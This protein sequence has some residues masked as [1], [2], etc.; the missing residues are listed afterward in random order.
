MEAFGQ[1]AAD[2][3]IGCLQA[4]HRFQGLFVV[5]GYY[6][7]HACGPRIGGQV[8]LAHIHK[9]DAWI[10]ELP[11]DNRLDLLAQGFTEPFPMI[12][13]P[14]PLQLNHLRKTY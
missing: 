2:V 8:N 7:H 5:S 11:F 10:A 9:A 12:F 4:L 13:L 1:F 6:D 14:A 3:A